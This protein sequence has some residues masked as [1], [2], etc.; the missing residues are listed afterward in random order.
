MIPIDTCEPR[1]R[2]VFLPSKSER[3]VL[4]DRLTGKYLGMSDESGAITQNDSPSRAHVFRS[5][6]GAIR[7]GRMIRNALQRPI[8]VVKVTP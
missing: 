7:H 5:F 8:E 4:A 6:D 1:G 3:Y 2:S